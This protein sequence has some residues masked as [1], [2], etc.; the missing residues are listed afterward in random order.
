VIV[1]TKHSV[2]EVFDALAVSVS[3]G[4]PFLVMPAAA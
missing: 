4:K 1:T 2:A 3:A